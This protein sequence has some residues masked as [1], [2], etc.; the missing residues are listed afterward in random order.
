[1]KPLTVERLKEL[2]RYE[3]DT[4]RFVRLIDVRKGKGVGTIKARAGEIAGAVHPQGYRIIKIDGHAYKAHRLAFF[5]MTGRWPPDVLDHI[6]CQKDDNRFE[7]LR[8][9]N[10]FQNARNRRAYRC[11]R[12]GHKGVSKAPHSDRYVAKIRVN[13]QLLHIGTYDTPSEA[14]EAYSRAASGL[15]GAF[16]RWN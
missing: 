7:N 13:N 15:H 16:A 14:A 2:M 6:N 10:A 4:G 11:N 8:H 5:Y 3:P 9:A 12:I 1:M